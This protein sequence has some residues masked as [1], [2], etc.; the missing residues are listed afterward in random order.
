[1]HFASKNGYL[2]VVKLLVESGANTNVPS[3]EGKLAICLAATQTNTDILKFLTRKDLD[4]NLLMEDKKVSTELLFFF[5]ISKY[6]ILFDHYIHFQ[7]N[8]LGKGIK[9]LAFQLRV[10]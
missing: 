1:M 6:K 5:L 10:K 3:K 2:N 8:T 9:P 7:T 4:T